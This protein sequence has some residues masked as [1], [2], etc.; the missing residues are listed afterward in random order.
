MLALAALLGVVAAAPAAVLERWLASWT[1]F[2]PHA[3]GAELSVLIYT[4]LFVAPLE[5]ALTVAA[6]V[7]SLRSRPR[8][9]PHDGMLT[10]AASALGL[11]VGLAASAAWG[12]SILSGGL[13]ATLLGLVARPLIATSWGYALDRAGRRRVGSRAFSRGW[14]AAVGATGLL[15]HLLSFGAKSAAVLGS[16][17]ILLTSVGLAWLGARNLANRASARSPAGAP[18]M[19]RIRQALRQADRPVLIAW[20]GFGTLV[21]TGV[22]IASLAGSVYLGHRFGIDF[23]AVDRTESSAATTTPLLLLVAA[24]LASFPVSGALVARASATHTI[25]EPALSAALTIVGVLVLMGLTASTAL[26]FSIAFA[27]VAFGL[28]CTGA[29]FGIGSERA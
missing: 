20:I 29:W 21:T 26:V 4:F 25:L 7:P 16:I 27:P 13:L 3:P 19:R 5:Q 18:S 15:T 1:A 2:D 6:A 9:T 11:S 28:A 12:S 23:A 24:A 14:L 22:L 17:A 8:H 10:A